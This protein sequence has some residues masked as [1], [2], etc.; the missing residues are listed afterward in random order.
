MTNKLNNLKSLDSHL[1]ACVRWGR[2]WWPRYE[3]FGSLRL[4]YESELKGGKVDALI[5]NQSYESCS[6][7]QSSGNKTILA[8]QTH[9][10][11]MDN[12]SWKPLSTI[13]SKFPVAVPV[14]KGVI[15]CQF[16]ESWNMLEGFVLLTL[17]VYIR[18]TSQTA[19]SVT[20]RTEFWRQLNSRFHKFHLR[21]LA[22]FDFSFSTNSSLV[23]PCSFRISL[24]PSAAMLRPVF[25]F[26]RFAQAQ[27]RKTGQITSLSTSQSAVFALCRRHFICTIFSKPEL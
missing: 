2:W 22:I 18:W 17:D 26:P 25:N 8:S 16:A 14:G 10:Q 23:G 11:N 12:Q 13:N 7:T 5:W 1:F 21:F 20:S 24:S 19:L 3:T 15:R 9:F 6:T 27:L 4:E